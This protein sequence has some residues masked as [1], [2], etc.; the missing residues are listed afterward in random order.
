MTQRLLIAGGYGIVGSAIA[1]HARATN[2]DVEI[3]LAGR[4][5]ERGA[6][7]ARQ[8]G[9]ARTA[10]LDVENVERLDQLGPIDLIVSALQDPADRLIEFA[11]RQ[12]V[13]HIGI[14][15]LA[16]E[17]APLLFA[18][19][20][21]PPK[22]P[23]VPLGHS[24]SGVMT[25][26]ALKMA[27]TFKRIDSIR[28]AGLYDDREQM[29]PMTVGDAES[30][31]GRA[32]VREDGRW[33]WVEASRSP[34]SVALA[35]GRVLEGLPMGLLDVPGLAAATGATNV[36]FD[37]IVGESIG[38]RAGGQP[39]QDLY[40]EIEGVLQSGE[41]AKRRTVVSDPRGQAHLTALGVLVAMERILGW[42]GDPPAA[43]GIHFPDTLVPVNAAIAR[44]EQFG[45]RIF[46]QS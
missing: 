31:I 7:L 17:L 45:V 19:A 18:A 46:D 34:R 14:T 41:P 22:R 2:Q 35:D 32:L 30:F 6:A 24:Q 37:F 1:R 42:N 27:E 16:D 40:I 44:F 38:T 9:N 4:S 5:P 33:A 10:Y 23:I 43:E 36:R 20:K 28:L 3:I 12:G 25:L 13:A 15:K 39:S 11:L 26:V 29:G 8:L 21:T